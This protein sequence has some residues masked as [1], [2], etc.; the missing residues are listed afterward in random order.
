MN[1]MTPIDSIEPVTAEKLTSPAQIAEIAQEWQALGARPALPAG[2]HL[3]AMLQPLLTHFSKK[4]PAELLAL[5]RGGRLCGLLAL[6][7]GGGPVVRSWT[8][9]LSFLGTPLID[10]ERPEDSLK[11]MLAGLR[12]K[13]IILSKVPATGPF[14]DMLVKAVAET[15]GSIEILDRWERA[16]LVPKATY[17]EWFNGN[18]ERKRRKEYKRLKARLGETGK[19]ESL[20][21]TKDEALEPWI[22]DL[23]GLEARGWKGQRGTALAADP[24]MATAFREALNHLAAEGSLRLWKIVFDGR[25][26]AM[27]SGMVKGDQGWLGK[28]AYDESFAKYSPGVMLVLDATEKLTDGER[29]AMVDSCAIPNH[30]MINNIWRDRLALCDVMIKAPGLSSPAFALL[31]KAETGRRRLRAAAKTAFYRIMR[32]HQS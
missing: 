14:W 21:W 27:M 23:I 1:M 30:P 31:H 7:K 6:K 15:R 25:P 3:Q 18:F 19:L 8:S 17:E 16:V 20:S 26:I 13:A 12:G 28:I 29:L 32:R 4:L 2:A 11:A 24:A 22:D 10:R 5:R 9:P